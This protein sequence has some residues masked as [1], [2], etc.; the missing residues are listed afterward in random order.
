MNLFLFCAAL[1]MVNGDESFNRP[2]VG[3]LNLGRKQAPRK[4]TSFFMITYTLAAFSLLFARFVGAA[5]VCQVD[6]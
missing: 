5:T 6:F 3:L 1:G 4:F 2:I